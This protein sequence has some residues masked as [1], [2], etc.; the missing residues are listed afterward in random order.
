VAQAV[1]DLLCK[2]EAL[3]PN[4]SPTKKEIWN[5]LFSSFCEGI[6]T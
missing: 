5:T 2:S 6:N 3:S 4:L 1:G